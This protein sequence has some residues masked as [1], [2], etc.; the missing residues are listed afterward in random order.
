MTDKIRNIWVLA[1]N[2]AG[3]VSQA[4]GVAEMLGCPFEVKNI[5]YNSFVKMPNFLR[6][7]SAIGI[8]S[9]CMKQLAPPYPD[10][11]I[12]AGRRSAPLARWIKKKSGGK[13]F[14]AQIMYPSL[15]GINDFDIVVVPNHDK[16]NICGKNI[17]RVTGS[18]HR[19]TEERLKK[20]AENWK[21]RFSHLPRPWIA[22]IVGGAT[23]SKPFTAGM[24]KK[25]AEDTKKLAPN[26]GSFLVT[27]SRRTGL[28]AEKAIY[29]VMPEQSYTY[30]WGD[31]SENPYFGFLALADTIVVTGD[32]MS[33]CSEAC[34][35]PVPVY[36]YSPSDTA[37][38]KH[39]KFHQE[40]YENGY[41]RPLE[42]ALINEK[43]KLEDWSHASLN[44]SKT[45]ADEIK[46]Q[47]Y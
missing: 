1:D 32:S 22:L 21:E 27:T 39:A 15:S 13:T 31:K 25:L 47:I 19:V 24:A 2:R 6:G 7:A 41:A 37:S 10:L 16:A 29:S 3:N 11:V 30:K 28:E 46:L 14:L 34:A 43:R 45:V 12:A 17:L 20:E 35:S 36:I 9:S 8:D 42:Q 38:D 23:K 33:M 18:P 26:G 5:Q 40:L 44:A 4:L